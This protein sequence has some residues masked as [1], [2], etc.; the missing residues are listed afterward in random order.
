MDLPTL[1]KTQI[2]LTEWFANTNHKITNQLRLE[3]NQKRERL[4]TLNQV[5]GLPFDK[6]VTFE[7]A[8]VANPTPK[9]STFIKT[10]GKELCAIRLMPKNSSLPKLRTRGDTIENSLIWFKQQSID[11]SK[12][13]V[14]FV[15]HGERQKWSTIFIINQYGIFGEVIKGGHYQLTQ[16]FYDRGEP[17]PFSFNFRTLIVNKQPKILKPYL[18]KIFSHLKINSLDKQRKLKKVFNAQFVNN[19]LIGYFE[20]VDT[21]EFG[22]WFIDYNQLLGKLYKEYQQPKTTSKKRQQLSGLVAS[23]GK[24][25]GKVKILHQDDL[26]NA[27]VETDEILVCI[28]T[29]PDYVT[30][31]RKAAAIITDQ[32][33]ILSHAAIISREFKIPCITATKSATSILKTGD[34]VEVDAYSGIITII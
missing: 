23:P 6:S 22:L 10:H 21:E 2:S 14:D 12:Y 28:M 8:D 4:D 11:P 26:K 33:G 29:T 34:L 9:F 1:Y 19:Y 16:G 20:T 30:H 7:G 31:M 13:T 18:R 32:G 15:P 5:I 24:V 27:S 3:D 25:T 17:I